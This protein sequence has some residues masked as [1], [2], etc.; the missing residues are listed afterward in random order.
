MSEFTDELHV[1]A[2]GP[3]KLMIDVGNGQFVN[4][5]KHHKGCPALKLKRAKQSETQR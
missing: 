3:F 2:C 1:C 5:L 4:Q